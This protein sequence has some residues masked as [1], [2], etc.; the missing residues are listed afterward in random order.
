MTKSTEEQFFEEVAAA[1]QTNDTRSMDILLDKGELPEPKEELELTPEPELE[2][3]LETVEEELE[4]EEKTPSEEPKVETTPQS[5]LVEDL[6][7]QLEEAKQAEHK[8]KSDAGRVPSLQR[9]LAELDKK[10]ADMSANPNKSKDASNPDAKPFTLKT[11]ALDALAAT[12]P[13]LAKAI[14]DSIA[15][16]YDAMQRES[17]ERTREVTGTFM[18]SAKDEFYAQEWNTLIAEVPNAKDVFASEEWKAWSTSQTPG[19][20][21]LAESDFAADV[22]LALRMFSGASLTPSKP[23]DILNSKVQEAR[24]QRL[25][26]TTPNSGTKGPTSKPRDTEQSLFNKI[27]QEMLDKNVR[28]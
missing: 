26:T 18:E 19:V 3:E 8:L 12:D 5:T 22:I 20:K 17:I 13:E 9:K 6:R 10:L 7:K 24:E 25:R 11:E 23:A 1:M 4:E 28:R 14:T 16:A 15:S 27:Y 2:K 21:A